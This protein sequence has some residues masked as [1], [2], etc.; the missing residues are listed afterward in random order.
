MTPDLRLTNARLVLKD[1][2]V[3]GALVLKDGCVHA[4]DEGGAAVKGSDDLAGDYLIPGLVDLHTDALESHI[5]PRRGVHW[6]NTAAVIA[7]DAVTIAAGITTVFDALCIGEVAGRAAQEEALDGMLAGLE[8]ARSLDVLRAE[9]LVHLRC[10]VTDPAV[11]GMLEPRIDRPLVKLISVMDHAPGHRQM[12]DATYLR[13][14]WMIGVNGM[15]LEEADRAIDALIERSRAVAPEMRK[16]V[17]DLAHERNLAVASHDDET[18]EHVAMAAD[19]GI[20]IAEFPTTRE[21]AAEARKRGLSVLMGGPNLV[22]GGS[23]SGNVAAGD[24]ARD[25]VL[26]ALMSD[27]VMSSMLMGAFTLADGGYDWPLHDAIATVTANPA[28][29]AG[30]DDRGRIAVGCRADLVQ[31]RLA[32]GK[33]V[34]R[35]VWREGRRVF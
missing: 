21:A 11:A 10:E 17:V 34:V 16:A 9:H 25:G 12:K 8:H 7:H 22:R 2:V 13:D 29:I 20:D 31:V 35:A 27:Y 4:I 30:L 14:T 15:S 23:H 32:D 19:L 3:E 28:R 1:R 6:D 5:E 33:P 18:E 24:L 26:D